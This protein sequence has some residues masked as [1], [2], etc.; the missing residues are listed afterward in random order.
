MERVISKEP[1]VIGNI[2]RDKGYKE[3]VDNRGYKKSGDIDVA[4]LPLFVPEGACFRKVRIIVFPML[5]NRSPV[6]SRKQDG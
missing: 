3:I 2:N 1:T 6:V 4:A 5:R